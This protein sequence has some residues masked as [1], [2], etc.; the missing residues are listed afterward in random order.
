MKDKWVSGIITLLLTLA[1]L[2]TVAT[3]TVRADTIIP[4]DYTVTGAEAWMAANSPYLLQ[5]SLFIDPGGH[6]TIEAGVT[7]QIQSGDHRFLVRNGGILTAE[8][9]SADPIIFTVADP[10]NTFETLEFLAG[11]SGSLAYCDLS[12]AGGGFDQAALVIESSS[13]TIDH[14]TIHDNTADEYALFLNGNGIS[15]TIQNSTIENNTGYAI[16][17]ETVDMM[18]IYHNLTLSDNGTDAVYFEWSTLYHDLTLDSQDLNGKPFVSNGLWVSSPSVLTLQPGTI[19]LFDRSGLWVQYGSSLIAEGISSQPITFGPSGSPSNFEWL[20]FSSGTHVRLDYCDISGAGDESNYA[21]SIGTSDLIMDHCLIHDNI[22]GREAVLLS[23][24]GISPTIQNTIISDNTGFAIAYGTVDKAPTYDNVTLTGNG[25]DAVYLPGGV[26]GTAYNSITLDGRGLNGSPYL[27]DGFT[28]A[29]LD[30]NWEPVTVTVMPGTEILFTENSTFT[31]SSIGSLVAKGMEAQ[32][33]T[34]AAASPLTP[35]NGVWVWG[36]AHVELAY[37]DISGAS[38]AHHSP[39]PLGESAFRSY[40]SDV[41]LDHCIVH[42]NS[43]PGE[44]IWISTVPGTQWPASPEISACR[45][46]HS[47][48]GGLTLAGDGSVRVWN[49]A[50]TDNGGAGL[51]VAGGAHLD[52]L[53]NTLARNALGLD[54]DATGVASLINTIIYSHTVG[55]QVEAGGVAT[56]T[57]T[58]W[59]NNVTKIVGVVGETGGLDGSAA[60]EVDGY[61]LSADSDALGQ[62][63]SGTGIDDDIDGD[64]RPVPPGTPPDLGADEYVQFAFEHAIYLPL[65]MRAFDST[66]P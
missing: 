44:A 18:P 60:F 46:Q 61:H 31:V 7:V 27:S 45:I 2:V 57:H 40:A 11:A 15:P 65:V 35:F 48:G 1:G 25:T 58:L 62:G 10:P 4:A 41:T 17:Q 59:D 64:P 9:T 37:C 43:A 3:T 34:I 30:A 54:V 14:C 50:I 51:A 36:D 29:S 28:V 55:V 6:L 33:I 26:P 16:G 13:V 8:G 66:S 38:G 63:A 42:D 21:V 19:L 22:A 53:H 49:N 23:G 39:E 47:T 5:G 56:L 52:A 24:S 20:N 12:G 32:P